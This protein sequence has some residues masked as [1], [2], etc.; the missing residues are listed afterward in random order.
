MK[1]YLVD[2]NLPYYFKIWNSENYIHVFDINDSMSDEEIW[3]YAKTNNLTIIS[4][5]VDF[6]NKV[7]FEPSPPSVIHLKI[8]NMK[9][10]EFYAFIKN[11]WD[12]ITQTSNLYKL[13]N[14]Y[15]DRIEGIG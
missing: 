8:G 6:S 15:L 2:A 13:T 12:E 1:K 11:N 3:I 5:D 10:K 14:V 9:M 4:K 7:L